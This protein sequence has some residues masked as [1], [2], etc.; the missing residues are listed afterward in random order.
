ALR[1]GML[2][3]IYL[4][5]GWRMARQTTEQIR[6]WAVATISGLVLLLGAV[7]ACAADPEWKVGL[8]QVKITPERPVPMSGSAAR[9]NPFERVAADLYVK[10]LVLEDRTG[11]RGVLVTSDLIGFPATV[12]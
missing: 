7:G 10:A 8:A 3:G 1:M 2:I 9:T 6:R 12:A 4:S 5:G 11:R